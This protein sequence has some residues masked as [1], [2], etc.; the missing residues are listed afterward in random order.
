MLLLVRYKYFSTELAAPIPEVGLYLWFSKWNDDFKRN[1]SITGN[2]G[3]AWLKT[4]TVSL[5]PH[6]R[7][8]LL[9][10]Y[11]LTIGS[12]TASHDSAEMIVAD[13]LLSMSAPAGVVMYPKHH[14]G[15]VRV[16]SKLFGS[17]Q[18]DQPERR[19]G[20]LMPQWL[21]RIQCDSYCFLCAWYLDS[22][23]GAWT[24]PMPL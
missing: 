11:P 7:H 18:E 19:S 22:L 17:L 3:F 21:A 1:H 8:K 2:R 20:R 23:H 10:T 15:L 14:C 13:G 16:R 9:H 12:K 6:S 5:T 24:L 4:I